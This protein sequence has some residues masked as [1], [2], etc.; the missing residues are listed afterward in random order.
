MN[1]DY[2][3]GLHGDYM[4]NSYGNQEY[5][6]GE[7]DARIRKQ[8][9]EWIESQ[10]ASMRNQNNETYGGYGGGGTPMSPQAARFVAKI[11]LAV[12][13]VGLIVFL[14]AMTM[15]SVNE[16]E[17]MDAVAAK[18]AATVAAKVAHQKKLLENRRPFHYRGYTLYSDTSPTNRYLDFHITNAAGKTIWTEPSG[19]KNRFVSESRPMGDITGKYD[20]RP[21][22]VQFIIMAQGPHYQ[23]SVMYRVCIDHRGQ[24]SWQGPYHA[25]YKPGKGY[26]PSALPPMPVFK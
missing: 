24:V 11:F 12:G 22:Q 9:M 2:Q 18:K 1:D 17:Q 23:Y 20:L 14:V 4:P 25:P 7:M 16:K 19:M 8:S 5:A 21:G 6:R 3:K 26:H 15:A 13:F 10:E